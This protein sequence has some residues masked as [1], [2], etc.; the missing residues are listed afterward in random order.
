MTARSLSSIVLAVLILGAV[1]STG[2]EEPLRIAFVH[3]NPIGEG[4]WT[5]SHERA[6]V[7]VQQH[8]GDRI[9]TTA[10]DGVVPGGD[11]ERVLTKL[12]RDGQQMIFATSFGHMSSAARVARRFP[13]VVFEHAAGYTLG[14]NLGTY[15]IRAYQGRY[16]AGYAAGLVTETN[17]IGYVGSFP[18]PEVMRGIN[19]FTLGAR[20]SNPDVTVEVIWISTWSDAGRSR[21]AAELLIAKQADVITH[22]TETSASIQAADQRGAWSVGYQSDRSAYAPQRH[23]VS[24]A[25]NWFPIYRDKI[26]AMLDGLWKPEQ[27]WVGVEQDATQL[28]GWGNTV[29]VAVV[30]RVAAVRKQMLDGELRVFSGPLTDSSGQQQVGAGETLTDAALLKMEWQLQGIEGSVPR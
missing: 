17:R 8:F 10:L 22:H 7:R 9:A 18:I 11:T 14:R 21:E 1:G 4:G 3:E 6:R 12:A 29:P 24:V 15:Q 26:Q 16:L 30:D 25:H 23:L 20:A 2:A 5:M 19:A 27:V 13:K 28:V